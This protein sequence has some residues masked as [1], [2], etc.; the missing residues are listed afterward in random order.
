MH[1]LS[2]FQLAVFLLV[3]ALAAFSFAAVLICRPLVAHVG[4]PVIKLLKVQ[5]AG[6]FDD[7]GAELLL[8]SLSVSNSAVSPNEPIYVNDSGVSLEA[9]VANHWI[10]LDGRVGLRALW[11]AQNGHGLEV[12]VPANA[13]AC[14]IHFKWAYARLAAG[15]MRWIAERSWC[16]ARISTR[17]WSLGW[18]G[19]P[20]YRPS[21][22][23]HDT[24][25]E[26]Q[27]IHGS[28]NGNA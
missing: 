8:V 11:P 4:G 17:L 15:R 16:P 25:V 14:R 5:P 1:R 19:F 2:H 20:R 26:L 9:N 27:V 24:A 7:A 10:P 28:L 3:G 21:S 6:V 12:V 22:R 18:G 23:W 13:T